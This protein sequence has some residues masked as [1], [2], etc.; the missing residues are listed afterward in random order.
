MSKTTV[1][2][3]NAALVGIANL[4]HFTP[5]K[6]SD[7]DITPILGM[8]Q[9]TVH[10]ENNTGSSEDLIRVT[11]V[12]TDRYMVGRYTTTY[13]ADVVGIDAA[14]ATDKPVTFLI[15]QDVLAELKV[16]PGAGPNWIVTVEISDAAI[17]LGIKTPATTVTVH[18]GIVSRT[19][20]TPATNYPAVDRLIPADEDGYADTLAPTYRLNVDYIAR[21]CKVIDP[22][23]GKRVAD[24]AIWDVRSIKP[25]AE[26]YADR[27][28]VVWLQVFGDHAYTVL[29]Q[30]AYP[31]R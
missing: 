2:I 21:I 15:P 22:R 31:R 8:V 25:S 18:N 4:V 11:A 14:A 10:T 12:S 7:R 19:G 1:T 3:P 9:V 24:D 16:K 27:T 23:G 29:L 5:R 6:K 28:P 13:A 17:D 26:Q 30:P 20:T